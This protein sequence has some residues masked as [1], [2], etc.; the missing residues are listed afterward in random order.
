MKQF[1][2]FGSFILIIVIFLI[3]GQR[4]D[5]LF[6][7][8]GA[9]ITR[10]S[11]PS[12]GITSANVDTSHTRHMHA[13][14]ATIPVFKGTKTLRDS[15]AFTG[16]VWGL[17]LTTPSAGITRAN[18]DSSHTRHPTADS[19]TI[20]VFKGNETHRADSVYF[21]DIGRFAGKLYAPVADIDSLV[22]NVNIGSNLKVGSVNTLTSSSSP[23]T[24]ILD[25]SYADTAD[26]KRCKMY[27]L[28]DTATEN[29]YGFGIGPRAN[30]TYHTLYSHE[31]YVDDTLIMRI[32]DSLFTDK[33]NVKINGALST[34]TINT[35]L[36]ATEVP[37]FL[38]TTFYDSLYDYTTYRSRVLARIIKVGN[39][40]TLYQPALYGIVSGSDVT[41]RGL[42]TSLLPTDTIRQNIKTISY[43]GYKPGSADI[44]NGVINLFRYYPA[45]DDYDYLSGS[46]PVGINTSILQWMVY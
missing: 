45:T 4:T 2:L 19:A 26:R 3:A 11:T 27:I 24:I 1:K 37:V 39:L 44:Y 7:S 32:G 18:I 23:A 21:A 31:F 38:D 15:T 35:G 5:T 33:R 30:F 13:D 10:L 9:N 40:V 29:Y 6:V 17:R 34:T 42:P 46:A 14:S 28:K 22:G 16:G 25:N 43:S 8:G 41:I 36:G 20:P 12:A